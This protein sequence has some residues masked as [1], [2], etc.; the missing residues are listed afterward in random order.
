MSNQNEEVNKTKVGETGKTQNEVMR[1]Q[2]QALV[3]FSTIF[4][5]ISGL[6]AIGIFGLA[7]QSE[8]FIG[9]V[10]P[11]AGVDFLNVFINYQ[12]TIIEPYK[13]RI[14]ELE[15]IVTAK[16]DNELNL[17]MRLAEAN[18]RPGDE[19]LKPTAESASV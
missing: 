18:S 15:A 13:K 4:M 1:E 5:Q 19:N 11:T 8:K 14:E 7:K 6:G 12:N 2:T 10:E 3:N 16:A 9:P 17:T